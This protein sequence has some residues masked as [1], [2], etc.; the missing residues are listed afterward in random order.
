MKEVTLAYQDV[1]RR[2]QAPATAQ[3][4]PQLILVLEKPKCF[5]ASILDQK[6]ATKYEAVF[7]PAANHQAACWMRAQ[8]RLNP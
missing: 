8:Q 1:C 6:E 2:L 5:P 4:G 7:S 3:T